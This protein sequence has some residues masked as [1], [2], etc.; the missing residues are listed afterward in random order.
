MIVLSLCATVIMVAFWNSF[1]MSYWIFCSVI[2]SIFDVA[3]SSKTILFA[4]NIALQM[5]MICLSPEEKF[6][7]FSLISCKRPFES[8]EMMSSSLAH[9]KTSRILS[10]LNL[11]RGSKFLLKVPVKRIGSWGMTVIF[12][13]R[14]LRSTWLISWLSTEIY[15]YS[16]S[17]KR[18][19]A[20]HSVLLPAPVLPITPNF[21]PG[22][23]LKLSLLSTV[24]QSGLYLSTTSLNSISPLAGHWALLS[25]LYSIALAFS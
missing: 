4:L 19:I 2:T 8:L 6:L 14:W 3:S 20:R 7:P 9:F 23:S 5:Q 10:S 21:S 11:L 22:L 17:I 16:I 18:L 12:E 1:F 13:R 24:S 25:L 15:P